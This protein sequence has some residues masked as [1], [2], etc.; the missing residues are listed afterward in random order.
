MM[1]QTITDTPTDNA[2]QI[3]DKGPI[4]LFAGLLALAIATFLTTLAVVLLIPDQNDYAKVSVLKHDRMASIEGPKVVL[5]GG[6]N[7]AFGVESDVIE[8]ATGC[9]TANMGMNGYFGPRFMLQEVRPKLNA[10][11]VVVIAFEWDNFGK[12]VDGS[13]K[14]LLAVAKSNPYVW[15]FL[16]LK[17]Q[18]MAVESM[19]FVAQAKTV[20]VAETILEQVGVI[21][22]SNDESK[23]EIN[24]IETVKAFDSKG[25]LNGHDGLIW[26]GEYEQG[27]DIGG[28]GLETKIIDLIKEFARDMKARDV[29]VIVS[30]TPTM[31]SYYDEQQATIEQAYQLLITGDD[32]VTVPRP[33]Q[34]YRFE[35]EYF[36]DTVYH[37]KTTTR[38]IRSQMIADDI[39]SIL[40]NTPACQSNTL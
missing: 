17:Q 20:R 28:A 11:D 33:P 19:P 14:D 23:V 26:D 24:D 21:D 5:V 39:N 35:T 18:G 29:T 25:D 4:R 13:G 32:A 40:G 15:Q 9:A 1:E 22:V 3:A 36:F 31:A 2:T 6:S 27:I 8:N 38:D 7:L 37:L 12:S 30:F 10:G 16:S 34:A